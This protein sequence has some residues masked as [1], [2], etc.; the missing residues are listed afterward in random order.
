MK[1]INNLKKEREKKEEKKEKKKGF[2]FKRFVH[3]FS[4][5]IG[6]SKTMKAS[7]SAVACGDL[8]QFPVLQWS[9]CIDLLIMVKISA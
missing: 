7:E 3:L 1:D 4:V 9:P 2:V 6:I 5:Y 8:G